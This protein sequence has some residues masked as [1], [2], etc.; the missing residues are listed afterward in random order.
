MRNQLILLAHFLTYSL[1]GFAQVDLILYNAN[2]LITSETE[3][4]SITDQIPNGFNNIHLTVGITKDLK[5]VLINTNISDPQGTKQEEKPIYTQKLSAIKNI[6]TAN[7]TPKHPQL[8]EI[9]KIL[10]KELKDKQLE[11][12]YV[13][14]LVNY[15]DHTQTHPSVSEY[16]QAVRQVVLKIPNQRLTIQSTDIALLKEVKKL[17]IGCKLSLKV[18]SQKNWRANI[19]QLG[20]NP[21]IYCPEFSQI[22]IEDVKELKNNH[23][24]VTPYNIN[25]LEASRKMVDWGVSGICTSNLEIP[26]SLK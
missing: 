22:T 25:T 10:E 20:F 19:M 12:S 8:W 5:I 18:T 26:I 3:L 9:L 11:P 17:N 1:F 15:L 2:D 21:D 24:M 7:G 14:E 16:S 13:I 6:K 4:S 23:I